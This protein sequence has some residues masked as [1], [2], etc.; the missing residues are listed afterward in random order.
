MS[1]LLVQLL[2]LASA[3]YPVPVAQPAA[4]YN[5]APA[6]APGFL[7]SRADEIVMSTQ[8][9]D[10]NVQ[11][12]RKKDPATGSTKSLFGYTVGSRAP[13][14]AVK[15]GSNVQFGYGIDNLYGGKAAAKRE[16]SRGAKG[17][18]L[19]LVLLAASVFLLLAA[20]K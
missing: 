16:A 19:G 10:P 4:Y 12:Y 7:A 11:K 3:F 15:S 2:A 20:S 8:Y 1:A 14:R 13:P 18:Q 5:Y 6:A 9:G 17:S